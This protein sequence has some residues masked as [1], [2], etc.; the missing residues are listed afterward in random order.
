MP[1]NRVTLNCT[2]CNKGFEV[3]K[4]RV[5]KYPRHFCS[6]VCRNRDNGLRRKKYPIIYH[7]KCEWCKG[8]IIIKNGGFNKPNRRFCSK[9]CKTTQNNTVNNPTKNPATRRKISESKKGKIPPPKSVETREK[10]RL[11]NL[12][13]KSHF[14]QG[15][16]TDRLH[17]YRSNAASR[18]WRKKVFERDNYTC[19]DCGIRSGNGVT[20]YLNADHIK[21]W[22]L[23]PELR[24]ELSNGRTLC[25][26][27]HRKT[28]TFGFKTSMKSREIALNPV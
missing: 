18:E 20:V 24:L 5:E 28:D 15:G 16:K 14:W 8:D 21:P 2:L 17:K 10:M 26:P 11:A 9:S 22:A 6:K 23:Y 4:S 13:S 12:G 19:Q 25:Q 3:I 1:R 7:K 27:C